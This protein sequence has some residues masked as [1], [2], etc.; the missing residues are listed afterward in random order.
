MIILNN[1]LPDKAQSR[2][3]VLSS[4]N[5]DCFFDLARAVPDIPFSSLYK[6]DEGYAL[7]L[8]GE[9]SLLR[10]CS[11]FSEVVFCDEVCLVRLKEYAVPL[12]EGNALEV[13]S[14]RSSEK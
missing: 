10:R 13:L 2:Y 11:E 14:G 7:Y 6:T 5:A 4:E 8:E 1:V 12:I 9:S 3:A